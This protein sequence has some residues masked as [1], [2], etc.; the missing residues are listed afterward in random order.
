MSIKNN[1]LLINLSKWAKRSFENF[2]T[3][4]FVHLL[5]HL[6]EHEPTIA[7]HLLSEM[8]GGE[9]TGVKLVE[10]DVK[11]LKFNTQVTHSGGR[12]DIEIVA[13]GYLIFIEVKVSA[14]L[15]KGQLTRY[16][17]VLEDSGIPKPNTKLILLSRIPSTN[18]ENMQ[19]DIAIRWTQIAKWLENDLKKHGEAIHA[20]SKYVIEQFIE[21]LYENKLVINPIKEGTI[22]KEFQEFRYYSAIATA[23]SG[24]FRSIDRQNWCAYMSNWRHWALTNMP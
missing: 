14:E 5:R 3:E 11:D 21:F 22:I 15:G 4:T 19:A 24:A 10:S 8:T 16:R 12:P 7:C 18:P 9:K 1:N 13:P 20:T 6:Q 17:K 2:T 23:T